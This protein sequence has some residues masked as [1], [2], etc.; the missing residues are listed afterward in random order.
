MQDVTK[1]T[2][3]KLTDR[4]ASRRTE[5]LQAVT[6]FSANPG[7]LCFA[8]CLFCLLAF[9]MLC[10]YNTVQSQYQPNSRA[11]TLREV[12]QKSQTS[13]QTQSVTPHPAVVRIIARHG[14][15]T[16]YGSG[17]LIAKKPNY[18]FIITNWHVVSD[19]NGYVEVRFP[20]KKEY[21]A[22]VV[23]VDDR[24]DLALL[25]IPEPK[26][27]VPVAIS[28]TIPRIGDNYW[29]AGYRGDGAYRMK[30]GRCLAFQL[31]EPDSV[32][33]ELI[34]IGVPAESGDSGGPV[35]NSRSELAGVLFGSDS[36]TTVASH[37]GRVIK[38]LQ[39]AA[40][41]VAS[42]PATPESVINAAS[43]SQES[44][45]D[46]GTKQLGNV[47]T[48]ETISLIVQPNIPQSSVSS[49]SSSSFG[50][51]GLRL[52]ENTQAAQTKSFTQRKR[53]GFINLQ[54]DT[55]HTA[56]R[57]T[58]GGYYANSAGV[59]SSAIDTGSVLNGFSTSLA[60]STNAAT[61][62]SHSRYGNTTNS[63]TTNSD[64]TLGGTTGSSPSRQSVATSSK[65]AGSTTALGT[66]SYA[67]PITQY[68]QNNS[69]GTEYGTSGTV[70]NYETIPSASPSSNRTT[71][72]SVSTA[73]VARSSNDT[74]YNNRTGS[75]AASASPAYS[76]NTTPS[77]NSQTLAGDRADA[78][79]FRRR[80]NSIPGQDTTPGGVRDNS[81]TSY[82]NTRYE[83]GTSA[84]AT[85]NSYSSNTRSGSNID[86][87][88]Q[89][90]LDSADMPTDDY[91]PKYADEYTNYGDSYETVA[92]VPAIGSTKFDA[93]KIVLAILVIFSILFY[94]VKA[95][96]IVEERA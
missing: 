42:L 27:V 43:L 61:I 75:R 20:D 80:Q 41:H 79:T 4:S 23:A 22:A 64:T 88:S 83:G 6:G 54:Y 56:A 35:F 85:Y 49:S 33:T 7:R 57:S 72:T 62:N 89:Y 29:V 52:R 19:T 1:Q 11:L 32:E 65:T 51:S 17:T 84:P 55:T 60:A 86:L 15:I 16:S 50:G 5:T 40:P 96:A 81:K 34:D 24:W 26:D 39:Q 68:E 78:S 30:G 63:G 53:H 10:F 93:V 76:Q 44:I 45:L 25:V 74:L 38:F 13:T 69:I 59:G 71:A 8:R 94:T 14:R 9:Q 82:G 77:A 73:Q 87:H 66:T 92:D 28:S 91:A 21:N 36:V 37:C 58:T 47:P 67:A 48:H 46:R 3:S 95:M 31:P 2:T 18:G 12:T 90:A 70:S